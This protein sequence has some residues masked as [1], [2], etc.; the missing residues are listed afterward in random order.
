MA[1]IRIK[2][3]KASIIILLN[4]PVGL[5]N[6][7]NLRNIYLY[8]SL[9]IPI[10]TQNDTSRSRALSVMV[11]AWN[12]T[13]LIM[14]FW[15]DGRQESVIIKEGNGFKYDEFAKLDKVTFKKYV[16]PPTGKLKIGG[17]IKFNLIKYSGEEIEFDV[18]K[19]VITC[20]R[21]T[22]G[23]HKGAVL[24]PIL[25]YIFKP[26]GEIEISDSCL[27]LSSEKMN[28][29][30]NQKVLIKGMDLR[31]TPIKNGAS[32]V[33]T[34]G[35]PD[36]DT[37]GGW[38]KLDDKRLIGALF[39]AVYS[40]DRYGNYFMEE[41]V[42]L[43]DA[44]G[45][46]IFDY[47]GLQ[48][49]I[50][51]LPKADNNGWHVRDQLDALYPARMDG[52][53]DEERMIYRYT[54]FDA[55]RGVWLGQ[56]MKDKAPIFAW[57]R[58]PGLLLKQLDK[59]YIFGNT[60]SKDGRFDLGGERLWVGRQNAGHGA[61]AHIIRSA[62]VEAYAGDSIVF[63]D[64]RG[65]ISLIFSDKDIL[66]IGN[67]SNS[68]FIFGQ[69]L[70]HWLLSKGLIQKP[71]AE[72]DILK[73][74]AF[75]MSRFNKENQAIAA[76]EIE[77]RI[78][79]WRQRKGLKPLEFPKGGDRLMFLKLQ[80][81]EWFGE[82]LLEED[83]IFRSKF[84]LLS[85]MPIWGFSFWELPIFPVDEDGRLNQGLIQWMIDGSIDTPPIEYIK[86]NK[87]ALSDLFEALYPYPDMSI[88][89]AVFY[90]SYEE[91]SYQDM[92]LDNEQKYG[93]GAVLELSGPLKLMA[94]NER[95]VKPEGNTIREAID[96]LDLRY[97]GIKVML[98]NKM[99]RLRSNFMIFVDNINIKSIKGL[100]TGLAGY[101]R[102]NFV[103]V[104]SSGVVTNNNRFFPNPRMFTGSSL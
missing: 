11:K 54:I 59:A 98:I 62:P 16:V 89:I 84:R 4:L 57:K 53:T 29:Y 52:L 31:V 74:K 100:D 69:D 15:E 33:I 66:R 20:I 42:F 28:R 22:S 40:W 86:A 91:F 68:G 79:R 97:P 38:L 14:Y 70:L 32:G 58:I 80:I 77:V 6:D 7:Y 82:A 63:N 61:V 49:R 81:K 35:L 5:L 55:K 30:K 12:G 71:W 88:E 26:D 48:L 34:T 104:S 67:L 47:K 21:V 95:W 101:R 8:N 65:N 39:E 13:K 9:R 76:D 25:I 18:E 50:R 83:T 99:G 93:D 41:V 45:N 1:Q 44:G 75:L 92:R 102:V 60:V 51:L 10:L 56:N 90:S 23:R 96:N 43:R 73:K 24:N 36:H 46:S 64:N 17:E 72:K 2:F 94:D 19:G 37:R 87:A 85:G 3:I 78:S 27:Q 103:F